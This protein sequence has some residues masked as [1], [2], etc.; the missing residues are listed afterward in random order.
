MPTGARKRILFLAHRVPYPPDKGDRIRSYHILAHL[1]RRG[2]VDLAYLTDEPTTATTFT[3]LR[4]L[5]PRVEGVHVSP[6]WRWVRA[7]WS[8]TRGRSL[9][10][11]LFASSTLRALVSRWQEETPYDVVVC[12]SS[13]VLPFVLGG[14]RMHDLIADLVDVDS[15]KWFDYAARTSGPKA[16]LFRLEGRRVRLLERAIGREARAVVLATGVEADLYRKICPEACVE[17]IPNGV[18]LDY[19]RPLPEVA[20][21]A[22]C[23]FVGQ[24]DYRANV[25][26]VEWFCR[27]AWPAI[28]ACFP[29][30]TFQVV[31]RNPVSAVQRLGAVP[32]V[33][34][35]GPVV[36]V[37]PYLASARIVLVP[38]PVARG[39][40]NKVLEAMAMG[41]AVV[42]SPA[43][44]EGLALVSGRDALAATNPDDWVREVVRLWDDPRERCALGQAARRY[45]EGNHRWET[46]LS[47]IDSLV[48][49]DVQGPGAG[50]VG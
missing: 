37:R 36:D 50:Q 2:Q 16:T 29:T 5:C 23:V 21:E 27:T 11:G 12:F 3:A 39:V 45:V 42:A 6:S 43:A 4:A 35:V 34:I 28:R 17:S 26:G 18:D 13:G 38:L 33:Q 7:A 48:G 19:F 22:H 25:L 44:L 24:L 10:E 1:A 47:R 46:C 40:Q 32:G 9:T 30:A 31:G 20:E 49:D 14:G 41:R 15:Q 8:L